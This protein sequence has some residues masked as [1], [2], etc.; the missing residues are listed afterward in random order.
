MLR[1][2][3]LLPAVALATAYSPASL[4]AED[5]SLCR[6]PSFAFVGADDVGVDET[7]VEAQSIA[8]QDRET[9]HLIGEVSL[10]RRQQKITAEDV[11]INKSTEQ[12]NASGNVRFE[13]PNYRLSSPAINID[14][15]S[16]MA[17]IETPLFE[18]P[19]NHARGQADEI[20][21]LDQFRSRYQNLA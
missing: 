16:D 3:Y 14:N 4:A 8:S 5:W 6:V 12:I 7:R 20:R 15:R 10:T 19:G 9:I 13:D 1:L 18:L 2:R 11:I 21:K 17:L